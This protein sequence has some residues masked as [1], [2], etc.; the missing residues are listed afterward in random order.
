MDLAKYVSIERGTHTSTC[1]SKPRS[2]RLLVD[3]GW[4]WQL[5]SFRCKT[6]ANVLECWYFCRWWWSVLN[7]RSSAEKKGVLKFRRSAKGRR[8]GNMRHEGCWMA[9]DEPLFSTDRW[10][11]IMHLIDAILNRLRI[12]EVGMWLDERSSPFTAELCQFW[13]P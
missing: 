2:S 10:P 6:R 5:V 4:S 13:Y 9:R 7:V 8:H 1:L 11:I 12:H 3:S